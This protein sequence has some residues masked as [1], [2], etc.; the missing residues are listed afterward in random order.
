MCM[1]SN[2][3]HMHSSHS[4]ASKL[5]TGLACVSMALQT[6]DMSV[7]TIIAFTLTT[8]ASADYLLPRSLAVCNQFD[9]NKLPMHSDLL[10]K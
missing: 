5:C 1:P 2:V 3:M 6:S 4:N 9:D 10:T 7:G 8:A